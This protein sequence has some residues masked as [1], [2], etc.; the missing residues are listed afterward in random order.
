ML[1][2]SMPPGVVVSMF[3]VSE[4]NPMPRAANSPTFSIRWLIERP[5][6]SSFQTTSVSPGRKIGERF[7]KTRPIGLAPDA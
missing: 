3:S 6:R 5:S 7:G 4:R 2:T 1:N